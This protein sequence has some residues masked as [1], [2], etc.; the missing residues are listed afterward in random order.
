VSD[1]D[2]RPLSEEERARLHEAR[3]RGGLCAACGRALAEGEAVWFERFAA[4][5]VY[6]QVWP[7]WAPVGEECAAPE[8]L[9]AAQGVEPERCLGCGRGMYRSPSGRAGL[10]FCSRRCSRRYHQARAE[11]GAPS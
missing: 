11:E 1:D 2:R 3:Y 4:P 7:W 5:G 8:T 10:P 9:R 6:G